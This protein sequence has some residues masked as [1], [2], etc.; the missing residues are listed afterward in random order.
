MKQSGLKKLGF[1]AVTCGIAFSSNAAVV[2]NE[3]DYDQP[4]TD[5]AEFIEL[6]NS[7]TSDTSLQNYSI[8]LINGSNSTPYRNIDLSGFSITAGGYFVICGDASLVANCDYS[9]T[10]TSGWMQ[11]GAPDAVALFDNANLLDSL[12]YEGEIQPYLEGSTLAFAD[13]NTDIASLSRIP[14]GFDIDDNG[15][16]FQSGCITPGTANI[17]GMGDCSATQVSAVPVPA[18]AWLFA[19]GILGLTGFAR[20]K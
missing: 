16:D 5:T 18:A 1:L 6:F 12:S 9:F 10:T 7:G 15:L 11:N 2:I 4:G 20:R 14:N 19:S 13:S 8:D 17:A 3:I